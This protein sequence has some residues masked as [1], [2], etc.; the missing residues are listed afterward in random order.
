[1]QFKNSLFKIKVPI[2]QA[3]ENK[4]AEKIEVVEKVDE[5]RRHMVEAAIVK[6]MKTRRKLDHNSL[7]ADTTKI[8]A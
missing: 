4:I 3:K 5:D 2:A 1:M 7:I 6:V 8:L